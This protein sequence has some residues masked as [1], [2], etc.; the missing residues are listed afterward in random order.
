M[1]PVSTDEAPKPP[2]PYSQAVRRGNVLA[3]AGQVGA[4]PQTG[5]M[6]SDDVAEQTAQAMR[7]VEAILRAAG[8]S[9]A[10]VVMLRVYLTADDDFDAMNRVYEQF[11]SEPYPSRTTVSVALGPGALVEIDALAVLA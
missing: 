1:Q 2:G 8:A 11:V 10:D 4:D 6:V 3:V 9:F 7:N 5:A